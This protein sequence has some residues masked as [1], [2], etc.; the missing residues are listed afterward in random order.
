[1]ASI[2]LALLSSCLGLVGGV[3]GACT[4]ERLKAGVANLEVELQRLE[5]LED[6]LLDALYSDPNAPDRTTSLRQISQIR[7]RLGI[8]LRRKIVA[9]SPYA[10]CSAELVM[11]DG[12]IGDAEDGRIPKSQSDVEGS[13]ARLRSHLMKASRTARAF[14]LLRGDH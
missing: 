7:R 3:A 8:N 4:I 1:M 12:F 13:F 2:G 5:S 6:N 11:L 10:A 14:A 9:S